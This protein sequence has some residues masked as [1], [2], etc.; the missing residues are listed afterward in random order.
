[1]ITREDKLHVLARLAKEFNKQNLLW[2]VGASI[3]L[4][5]KGYV[6]NFN[7]LDLLVAAEDAEAM[8]TILNQLGTPLPTTRGTFETKRFR[9]FEVDSV[10]IDMIGG[11]AI[12]SQGQVYD[13]D[14]KEDQVT[15]YF[16]LYGEQIPLHSVSLWHRYYSLMGRPDKVEIIEKMQAI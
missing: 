8:E 15:G 16:A 6:D 5:L 7:D 4:Y 12:V 9:K 14:L 3:L 1:M 11:F 13:C 10:E 2:A